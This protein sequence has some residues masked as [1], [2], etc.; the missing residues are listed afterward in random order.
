M[1]FEPDYATL[2]RGITLCFRNF[3]DKIC[4]K[5]V[6]I[7][8]KKK[9]F[10]PSSWTYEKKKERHTDAKQTTWKPSVCLLKRTA[11]RTFAK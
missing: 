8:K 1:E 2:D 9:L 11:A 10:L 6:S 7:Y 3:A 5:F 4:F